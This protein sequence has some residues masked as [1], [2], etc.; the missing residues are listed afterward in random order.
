MTTAEKLKNITNSALFEQLA[1]SVLRLKYPELAGLIAAG[2]NEKNESVKSV[3]DAFCETTAGHFALVA[4]TI[5][6]SNLKKKWLNES[7]L[8]KSLKGDLIKAIEKIELL[9]RLE[10]RFHFTV[11]LVTNQK[12]PF[13]LYTEVSLKESSIL[14]IK[15]IDFSIIT[16]FLDNTGDGQYLRKIYLGVDYTLLSEPILAKLTLRNK[17][18]YAAESF[19]DKVNIV[20]T[21]DREGLIQKLDAS[22]KNLFLLIGDS[23][24]GKSSLCY[25]MM[26]YY[27]VS[28]FNALRI[29][30]YII[31]HSASLWDAIIE[32]LKTEKKNLHIQDEIVKE[33]FNK[34][35]LIIIDDIN[36][37]HN[38]LSVLNKLISLSENSSGITIVCPIWSR[39]YNLL[40]NAERKKSLYDTH[41]ISKLTFKEGMA[42]VQEGLKESGVALTH[43]EIT[44]VL[45]EVGGD[46]LLLGLSIDLIKNGGGN[47]T[48]QAFGTLANF[49]EKALFR[50]ADEFSVPEVLL[51]QCLDDFGYKMLNYKNISPHFKQANLWWTN[52]RESF[53]FIGKIASKRSIFYFD[54]LGNIFFRHDRIRDY[55]LARAM[56]N[57]INQ[58]N[59][60]IEILS[61]PYFSEII[62]TAISHFDMDRPKIEALLFLTPVAVFYSFKYLQDSSKKDQFDKMLFWVKEWNKLEKSMLH[63]VRESIAWNFLHMDTKNIVELTNGFPDSI[64]MCLARF[65]N[66]DC[67]GGIRY[68]ML[69]GLQIPGFGLEFSPSYDIDWRDSV[70][71]HVKA[72]HYESMVEKLVLLLPNQFDEKM[73]PYAYILAGYLKSPKLAT[74]LKANWKQTQNPENYIFYLWAIL[75]CFDSKTQ[76]IL[77]EALQYWNQLPEER[78]ERFRVPIGIKPDIIKRLGRLRWDFNPEQIATLNSYADENGINNIVYAILNKVDSPIAFNLTLSYLQKEN[79]NRSDLFCDGRGWDWK[80]L[81]YER[82]KTRVSEASLSFLKSVCLNEGEHDIRRVV[83]LEFWAK[84]EN[85]E[86]VLTI[87][88]NVTEKSGKFYEKTIIWRALSGDKLVVPELILFSK[89]N[90]RI[91]WWGQ[92]IWC[93]E[94]SLCFAELLSNH[95]TDKNSVFVR[96]AIEMLRLIDEKD[97]EEILSLFW[98]EI[99]CYQDAVAT[100]LYLGTLRTSQLAKEEINRLGFDKGDKIKYTDSIEGGLPPDLAGQNTLPLRKIFENISRVFGFTG[101][102]RDR[103]LPV[104]KLD[105]LVQY[106]PLLDEDATKSFGSYCIRNNYKDWF[107]K[108]LYPALSIGARKRFQVPTDED[109]LSQLQGFCKNEEGVLEEWNLIDSVFNG[110]KSS[111]R[112]ISILERFAK[113]EYSYYGLLL[114]G[115]GIR[116]FGTRK[117]IHLIDDYSFNKKYEVDITT[118]KENL[119]YKILQNN[120]N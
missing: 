64:C 99:K 70:L 6:D 16:D 79:G 93:A 87:L 76:A 102:S 88:R 89:K 109:I 86:I 112:I 80:D 55:I 2:I 110:I 5:N 78:H 24:S 74:S 60:N 9:N 10:E 58:P 68:F 92:K 46:P 51:M 75:N 83:A 8:P 4:Y 62:G 15:I 115:E 48:N 95:L 35:S 72:R 44:S 27:C 28:G 98:D 106:L 7:N 21:A 114:L 50:M 25:S 3:F 52:D 107:D 116:K 81:N 22:T 57:C 91:I 49:V 23:G 77:Y 19:L 36:K 111:E 41:F 85:P 108:N 40:D 105:T 73:S 71:E 59:E 18:E 12:V 104:Q 1:N 101:E 84:N 39:N 33:L 43:Q 82:K 96:I 67:I 14:S 32:Q 100:A 13:E 47:L 119:K 45:Q 34:R 94:L 38:P 120:L 56:L 66:G 53:S 20:T 17:K 29:K 61:D 63:S 90:N 69:Y 37:E 97:A 30:P 11:Y 65:K 31:Q 26:E 117:D 113:N 103:K 118:V 54:T 42:L